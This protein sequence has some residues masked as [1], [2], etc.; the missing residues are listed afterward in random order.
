MENSPTTDR[1][2][3]SKLTTTLLVTALCSQLP[4]VAAFP[5]TFALLTRGGGIMGV[6]PEP[7]S[8]IALV[9]FFGSSIIAIA[10]LVLGPSLLG[11]YLERD[12]HGLSSGFLGLIPMLAVIVAGYFLDLL[13]IA[14]IRYLFL[15][16][17][18]GF[19]IVVIL[20][21]GKIVK[22]PREIIGLGL[23]IAVGIAITVGFTVIFNA[24]YFFP[25]PFLWVWLSAVFFPE[26]LSR[27][28]DWRG[29]M[30]WV[31]VMLIFTI[32]IFS[33]LVGLGFF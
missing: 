4:F 24:D 7:D 18:A 29:L 15:D 23:G 6:G 33:V 1:V 9:W 2:S 21:V 10:L 12:K 3:L 25:L 22:L 26:F 16:L 27:R 31:A 30:I 14:L 20:L 32:V 5:A 17:S 8:T 19:G 11:R 13:N 28:T